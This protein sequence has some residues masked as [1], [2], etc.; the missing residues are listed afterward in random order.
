VAIEPFTHQEAMSSL[1]VSN[2]DCTNDIIL[3]T[4]QYVCAI[5]QII[6]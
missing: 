3:F 4:A 6:T 1:E 2:Y 5:K